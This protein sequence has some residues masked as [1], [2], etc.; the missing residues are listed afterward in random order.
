MADDA[1]VASLM[2]EGEAHVYFPDV[3]FDFDKYGL[4]DLGRGRVRQIAGLLEKV[5]ELNIVLQGHADYKGS[6]EYNQ[7]LGMNRADAVQQELVA[8]GVDPARLS[9]VSFGESQPVFSEEEDWARAVNRRVEV[10]PSTEG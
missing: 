4:N 9:T 6:D 10:Q 7:A 3:N 1:E 8:M 2:G 5:P